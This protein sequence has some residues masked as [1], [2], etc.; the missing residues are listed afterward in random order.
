MRKQDPI[1]TEETVTFWAS[2]A[3]RRLVYQRCPRCSRPSF[4]PRSTCIYCRSPELGWC[5]SS[6]SGRVHSFTVVH[7]AAKPAFAEDVPYVLAIVELEEGF[8]M[9]SNIL[10]C[11]LENVR[12]GMPVRL[13]FEERGDG[14]LLPQFEAA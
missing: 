11:E 4:P 9:M 14:V 3:Q 12:I 7:R 10:G 2:C 8:R 1:P 6:G 5:Q 13:T